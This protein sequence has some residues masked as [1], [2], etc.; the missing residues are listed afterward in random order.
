MTYIIKIHQAFKREMKH[1]CKK[2]AS[3]PDD[4]AEFLESLQVDPTQGKPL[5]Q[6]CFKVRLS[7]TTKNTGKDGG[8]RVITCVK[9]TEDTIH[10]LSIYDKSERSTVNRKELKIL[11]KQIED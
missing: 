10:L 8:A 7:I 6:D 11:L 5:G 1:L 2:Y 4:Y 9:I 3:M